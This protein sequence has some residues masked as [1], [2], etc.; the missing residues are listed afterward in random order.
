M[1]I[2]LNIDFQEALGAI[3]KWRHQGEGSGYPELMI[4]SDLSG[5]GVHAN[6][7]I[8]SQKICESF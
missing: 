5:S 2:K 1:Q 7:E 8:T 3:K 6:S 4:K